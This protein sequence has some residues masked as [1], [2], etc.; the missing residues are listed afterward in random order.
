MGQRGPAPLSPEVLQSRGSRSPNRRRREPMPK[1]GLPRCPQWLSK[2]AKAKWK[3]L[4]PELDRLGLLTILDGENLSV[5]CEAWSEFRQ[6]TEVLAAEGRYVTNAAGTRVSHPA[7]GQ[8]RSAWKTIKDYSALFGLNPAAR[9][10][11]DVEPP[12]PE[13]DALDIF[14]DAQV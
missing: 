10:R 9:G 3:A 11:L 6:S 7:V 14:L 2:E 5:L 12:A 1:R 8:Q 13:A 4:V